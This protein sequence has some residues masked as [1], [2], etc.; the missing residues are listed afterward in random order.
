[1]LQDG[2]VT[3]SLIPTLLQYVLEQCYVKEKQHFLVALFHIETLT[4]F[5]TLPIGIGMVLVGIN[6]SSPISSSA[7]LRRNFR[8]IF[9]DGIS[10]FTLCDRKQRQHSRL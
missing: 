9:L 6:T 2:I 4:F 7:S 8:C 5:Q 1:M 10:L 3:V